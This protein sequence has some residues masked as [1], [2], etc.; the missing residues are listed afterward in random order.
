MAAGIQLSMAVKVPPQLY[1]IHL[2]IMLSPA[3]FAGLIYF[4]MLPGSETPGMSKDQLTVFQVFAAALSV[5]A[6]SL[7]QIIHRFIFRGE[8]QVPTA[9]YTTMKI[10][11]WALLEGA[12]LFIAVI[13]FM[14]QEK[15]M[16]IPLGVL[17]ALIALM[18]PTVDEMIRHNVRG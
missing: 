4:V 9:K 1:L 12:A 14:S 5:I 13:F 15:S 16:L 17:I 2:A 18:R 8:K 10:V 6:V 7:S 11:Q 3:I